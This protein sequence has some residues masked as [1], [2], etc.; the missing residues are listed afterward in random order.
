MITIITFG[1]QYSFGV[2]FDPLQSEFNWTRA[3]I[4]GV[5]SV[6]MLLHCILAFFA[7]WAT[8][9]FGPKKVVTSGGAFVGVGLLLTSQVSAPWQLYITYSLMLSIGASIAWTP[10]MTT[11][12][13]WF[14]QKRGLASGIVA[15]GVGLGTVILSPLSSWL[16]S[17]YGWSTSYF[18]LGVA[19]LVIIL[20]PAQLLKREPKEMGLLPYGETDSISKSSQV[21]SEIEGLTMQQALRTKNLWLI[22]VSYFFYAICIF[23]PMGHVVKHAQDVGIDPLVAATFLSVIGGSSIVGRMVMGSISDKI[24]RRFSIITCLLLLA[25]MMFC[26]IKIRSIW[27]FYVFSAIFGFGY[28]GVVPTVAALVGETFGLLNMGKIYGSVV[29]VAGFGGA[30]SPVLAGYIFDTSHSYSAAF[31]TG[32]MVALLAAIIFNFVKRGNVPFHS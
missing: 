19:S 24:G 22:Y 18:I 5:F 27:A 2:F 8:D 1:V 9:K 3:Q 11:T 12:S 28:G 20:L 6:Y 14:T 29:M 13:R 21:P 25:I 23:I 15:S 26:L 10:L 16:I 7:G 4:S 30:V 31:F 32:G 17:A